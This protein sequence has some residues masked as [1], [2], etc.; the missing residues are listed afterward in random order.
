MDSISF[1]IHLRVYSLEFHQT[2]KGTINFLITWQQ[3]ISK[4][5]SYT[6]KTNFKIMSNRV[7]VCGQQ[8]IYWHSTSL[9]KRVKNLDANL[10]CDTCSHYV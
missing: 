9:R 5:E 6:K 1:K 10:D 3:T 8:Y 4:I 2:S 7:Y